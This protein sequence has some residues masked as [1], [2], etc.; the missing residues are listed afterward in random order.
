[1][2]GVKY[3]SGAHFHSISVSFVKFSSNSLNWTS[4]Y[5][6][7][8]LTSLQLGETLGVTFTQTDKKRPN[9]TIQHMC[10]SQSPR[11]GSRS[12][13]D[14]YPITIQSYRDMYRHAMLLWYI[15]PYN[16][17]EIRITI[18]SYCDTHSIQYNLTHTSNL[19]WNDQIVSVRS[20]VMRFRSAS[21]TCATWRPVQGSLKWCMWRLPTPGSRPWR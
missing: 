6:T 19:D 5:P 11:T 17:T 10:Q 21:T 8:S 3:S 9:Q 20:C 1:M 7:L 2:A 4:C 18:Q 16:L 13:C 12:S 15:S 14:M